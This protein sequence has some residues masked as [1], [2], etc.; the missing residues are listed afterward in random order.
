MSIN[1]GAQP[2]ARFQIFAPR[3]M[4]TTTCANSRPAQNFSADYPD[5][6]DFIEGN[7]P[8]TSNLQVKN[9]YTLSQMTKDV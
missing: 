2:S 4:F 7:Q 3:D 1:N 8:V 6:F 5:I 9:N